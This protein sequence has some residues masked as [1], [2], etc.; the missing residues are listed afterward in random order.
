MPGRRIHRLRN[1]MPRTIDGNEKERRYSIHTKISIDDLSRKTMNFFKGL[2]LFG[3]P[4]ELVYNG[5]SSEGSTFRT[6]C[7]G[8]TTVLTLVLV[9]LVAFNSVVASNDL[10]T[11]KFEVLDQVWKTQLN[12]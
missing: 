8:L 2:D 9:A 6:F 11:Q 10:L 12:E 5:A 1:F 7:G 3:Q 4:V